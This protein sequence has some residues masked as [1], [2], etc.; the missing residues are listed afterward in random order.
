MLLLSLGISAQM[1]REK[2]T[3]DIKY[4]QSNLTNKH[5]NLFAL[6]SETDFTKDINNIIAKTDKLSDFE[7]ALK[8]QQALAKQGDTHT[9]LSLKKFIKK[10]EVLPLGSYFFNDD[11][12]ITLTN[13]E[14]KELLGGKILAINGF[15]IKT[16]TD[17]LST[18]FPNENSG[19]FRNR[20][21]ELLPSNQSLKNFGFSK[22][23]A[24]KIKF[25]KDGKISEK[26]VIPSVITKE[27]RVKITPKNL[28]F[29][30]ENKRKY[31]EKK[32]FDKEKILYVI[33][34]VC[35]TNEKRD[36]SS[37]NPLTFGE[38]ED[39]VFKIIKD[40]KID[41]LIFD[42]RNNGVGSSKQGTDFIKKLAENKEI[43]KKGHLFVVLGRNTFS[44]AILNATDFQE[45]T[46]AIFVGEETSGKPNH[47]GELQ[48][49][50]LPNSKLK[51]TYSTY[52]FVRTK[53]KNVNTIKPDYIVEESFYD[54]VNGTD[55]VFEF[56]KSYH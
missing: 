42:M 21:P 10:N 40:N 46:K 45:E 9:N 17:S 4:L 28:T 51:L 19:I 26:T 11:I 18:L 55:P 41:K 31:F 1:G 43:N 3:E 37:V 32:Y 24:V 7:I 36:S 15:N 49:L 33:Y 48:S 38:F 35:T 5:Y 39:S 12:Y 25:E 6:R 23:D 14:N 8:L 50:E 22:T 34:N 44:S 27:N 16:V 54:Y 20:I 29:A 56:I 52:Y 30:K 2:W 47:Y 53:K 13:S